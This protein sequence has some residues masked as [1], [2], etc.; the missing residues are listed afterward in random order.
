MTLKSAYIYVL[1]SSAD[2]TGMTVQIGSKNWSEGST[3]PGV[4]KVKCASSLQV[5][6]SNMIKKHKD[7]IYHDSFQYI[8]MLKWNAEMS[9]AATY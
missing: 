9:K 7:F 8:I 5:F 3:R 4:D 1:H 2:V 6:I